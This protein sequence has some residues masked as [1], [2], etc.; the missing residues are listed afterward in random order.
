MKKLL[1]ILLATLLIV[2]CFGMVGCGVSGKY[3]L[4]AV[5]VDGEVYKD[6]DTVELTVDGYTIEKEYDEWIELFKG[7]KIDTLKLDKEGDAKFLG[8]SNLEWEKDGKEINLEGEYI[9]LEL[10]KKG[11]KLR[12]DISQVDKTFD[13]EII[14]IYKKA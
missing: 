8:Y 4:W 5:E 7:Y 11:G 14:L 1:S 3:E 6:G 13:N 12:F 2:C 10:R 9:E